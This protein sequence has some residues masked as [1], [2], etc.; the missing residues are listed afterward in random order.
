ML[1]WLKRSFHTGP[2][3]H[4][5]RSGWSLCD[6][7]HLTY[8]L[9]TINISSRWNKQSLMHT[10]LWRPTCNEE[11]KVIIAENFLKP[12]ILYRTWTKSNCWWYARCEIMPSWDPY[13]QFSSTFLY[14]LSILSLHPGL[15]SEGIKPKLI[16]TKTVTPPTKTSYKTK[17][18]IR[19]I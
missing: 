8:N 1:W 7:H 11:S 14:A 2:M 15:E 12:S 17:A 18:V 5:N 6:P 16:K 4:L 19:L 9:Y 3:D 10:P 13:M